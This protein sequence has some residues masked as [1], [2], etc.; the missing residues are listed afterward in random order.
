MLRKIIGTLSWLI[1]TG[2]TTAI[3]IKAMGTQEPILSVIGVLGVLFATTGVYMAVD[4]WRDGAII[5]CI[6]GLG[7]WI[8]GEAFLLPSEYNFW[9]AT[10]T[11][12]AERELD[13]QRQAD[14]RRLIL[15]DKAKELSRS[16]KL[17]PSKEIKDDINEALARTHGKKTLSALT[18]GCSDLDSPSIRFCKDVFA[19]RKELDVSEEHEK[20]VGLIWEANTNLA[21]DTRQAH[22][23]HDGPAN[24]ADLFGGTAKF[25]SLI[26][27]CLTMILMLYGRGVSIFLAWRKSK[28]RKPPFDFDAL[29]RKAEQDAE[30]IKQA[31]QI[32]LQKAEQP[33]IPEIKLEQIDPVED[34]IRK[35]ASE[36]FSGQSPSPGQAH[37]RVKAICLA[38]GI[39]PLS[40]NKVTR[41]LDR[42]AQTL[43]PGSRIAANNGRRYGIHK[44]GRVGETANPIRAV[45]LPG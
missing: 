44:V 20:S 42:A 17:R 28:P 15:D 19:L 34:E 23:A 16:A 25:W 31:E 21:V 12:K 13:I 43:Q 6:L 36:I 32:A 38:H 18:K 22:G 8:I 41:K 24:F 3:M 27:T 11:A 29:R 39:D 5:A 9:A 45:A 10:V 2:A 7:M 30:A 33:K 4:A 26:L 1:A 14:G 35:I 40:K 37:K